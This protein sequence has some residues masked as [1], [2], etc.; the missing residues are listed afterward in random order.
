MYIYMHI[1]MYI[2]I[3]MIK[4]RKPQ[5]QFSHNFT[6][7][8]RFKPKSQNPNTRKLQPQT[9]L[10]KPKSPD[11]RARPLTP[12]PWPQI[13]TLNPRIQTSHPKPQTPDP[14]PR[15]QDP[16]PRPQ[17]PDP[18]PQTPRSRSKTCL[19]SVAGD[20]RT[21][22]S[23]PRDAL[24]GAKVGFRSPRGRQG[25]PK[26]AQTEPQLKVAISGSERVSSFPCARFVFVDG[27]AVYAWHSAI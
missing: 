8:R 16:D 18:R 10:P 17:T 3:I 15:P 14:G 11:P 25:S 2:Y 9:R 12:D 4:K 20:R 19:V 22:I 6:S 26:D 13:Q 23:S 5:T 21:Q 24:E 27:C 7:D 1:F